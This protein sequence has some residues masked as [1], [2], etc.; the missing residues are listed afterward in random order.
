MSFFCYLKT[1]KNDLGNYRSRVTICCG[2]YVNFTRSISAF[3]H[4]RAEILSV[5]YG[6]VIVNRNFET[7]K[8]NQ[9]IL[10]IDYFTFLR[11]FIYVNLASSQNS[12]NKIPVPHKK[13][14]FTV[15]EIK[16]ID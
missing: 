8:A 3:N 11:G 12:Q 10:F 15:S 13:V 16:L 1:S 14:M 5:I 4:V 7:V 6:A 2:T 9:N